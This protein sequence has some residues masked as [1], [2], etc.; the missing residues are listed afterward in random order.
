M[1]YDH[2]SKR[3][4]PQQI[5][6]PLNS[7][8]VEMI[9]RLIQQQDVG[10]LNQRLHDRQAASASLRIMTRPPASRSSK[11]ARPSV[12]AKWVACSPSA[13]DRAFHRTLDDRPDRW[14]RHANLDS[15]ST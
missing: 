6:E 1:A 8:E 5:F 14:R 7:R 4:P 15:C 12:S 2:A 9:R 13:V 10:R 3:R 11:P